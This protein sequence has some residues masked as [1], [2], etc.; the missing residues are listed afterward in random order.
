MGSVLLETTLGNIV[1]DVHAEVAPVASYNFLK[2]SKIKFYV[3]SLFFN[4]LKGFVVE[5]GDPVGIGCG[6]TSVFGLL[7]KPPPLP[8]AAKM[9]P[10][11][12]ASDEGVAQ[13][14]VL[15]ECEGGSQVLAGM[16]SAHRWF[17]DEISVLLRHDARGAVAMANKAPGKNGSQFYITLAD[18][19]ASLDALN[20]KHTV[21]G[22]VAEGFDVLDALDAAVVDDAG[23]P[24]HNLRIRD[25]HVLVDPFPDPPGLAALAPVELRSPWRFRPA[26]TA[27]FGD[28]RIDDSE[29]E[30]TALAAAEAEADAEGEDAEERRLAREARK[31]A[32]V[33]EIIGDLPSADV[34]PP[35]TVLFVCKLNPVTQDDDLHTIFSQFGPI[36]EC[37]V[38]RDRATGDSLCYAFIEFATKDDCE[39]AYFKMDNALIDDRRIKVDFSQSHPPLSPA[40]HRPPP[41]YPS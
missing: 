22:Q 21:F 15:A 23:R 33:L 10:A 30:T 3:G 26:E 31:R 27:L 36:V 12:P 14:Q 1:I 40:S 2:L 25:T 11:A 17:G 6:G 5:T 32:Q 8:M 20:G 7:G 4:V 9:A 13:G 24:F 35:D 18:R 29:A 39:R 37:A 19:S 34:A 41:T 38:V 16:D 28:S